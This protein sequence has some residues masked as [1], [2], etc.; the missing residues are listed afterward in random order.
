MECNTS[1]LQEAIPGMRENK[2]KINL[3]HIVNGLAIGGGELKLLEL[4]KNLVEKRADKY[5]VTVCSVG[6][7]GTLQ[8]EFERLGIKVFVIE[9]KHKFDLSQVFKVRKIIK[10]EKVDL[11]QTTLFYADVIGALAAKLAGVKAVIS[12][13]TVSHPPD[14][15]EARLRHKLSYQFCMRFVKKI[16]AVSEGVKKYLVEERKIDSGKIDIIH[17]GIDLSSFKTRNGFLDKKT[18]SK[19]GIPDHKIVIGTVARL[20]IQKGHKYLIEAAPGIISKFPDVVFVFAGDGTLRQELELQVNALGL[21]EHFRFLGFRK[22]VK[23]LLFAFDIF[24]LPSLFEGLPNVILEAMASGRPIVAS[25]VDGT[26]ELLEH[27][28][29]GLL[30][31]PKSPQALQSALLNLLEKED[32]G[33]KLGQ[34]AK[35]MAEQKFSFEQQFQKF[36]KVYDATLASNQRFNGTDKP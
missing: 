19:L 34:Q 11:V 24:V 16:V 5:N 12:W 20:E 10:E 21:R 25:A 18:R 29:T 6:Q 14:S 31:P 22:D 9:K 26:P 23:E 27:K 4:V 8:P 33:Q 1:A 17:Y 36:E 2:R 15:F 28:E 32:K 35:R 30:V 13:D 7:G 3:L